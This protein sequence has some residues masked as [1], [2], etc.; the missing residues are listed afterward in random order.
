MKVSVNQSELSRALATVVK[1]SSSRS[2]LSILSGILIQARDGEIVLQTT[3][4]KLS[5]RRYGRSCK[6]V[7]RYCEEPSRYGSE[8]FDQ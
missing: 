7:Q 2:T 4:L 6:A 1:G 3:D 5:I 8:Y